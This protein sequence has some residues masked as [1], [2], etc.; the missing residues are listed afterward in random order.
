MHKRL[1]VP[2]RLQ[3]ETGYCLPACVEM[4]LAYWGMEAKQKSLARKLKT[5]PG[6]G[7]PGPRV[8]SLA[9]KS[10]RVTYGEGQLVDLTQAIAA[11]IPPIVL[12]RTV[13][14][15]I[16]LKIHPMRLSSLA[17]RVICFTLMIRP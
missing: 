6:V 9:S 4:V 1:A 2:H 8:Q 5:I 17:W 16:G 13:N 11:D 14:Y 7:T 3:F 10:L 12:V 15:P